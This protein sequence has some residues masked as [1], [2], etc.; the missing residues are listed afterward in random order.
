MKRTRYRA[1][2]TNHHF[3]RSRAKGVFCLLVVG[4]W[5]LHFL[6]QKVVVLVRPTSAVEKRFQ[7][8]SDSAAEKRLERAVFR[9]NDSM[10]SQEQSSRMAL[11]D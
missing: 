8:D 5:L 7:H 1:E 10:T 4:F 6:W 9:T 11:P 2:T 3:V